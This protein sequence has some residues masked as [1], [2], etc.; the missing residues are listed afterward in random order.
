MKPSNKE[1]SQ[2]GRSS[3]VFTQTQKEAYFSN[4]SANCFFKK[5]SCLYCLLLICVLAYIPCFN[6]PLLPLLLVWR[7]HIIWPW[8]QTFAV[9]WMLYSFFWV[10]SRC[11][12]FI[13]RRFGTL[14]LFHLHRRAGM[15]YLII[16]V[17]W[18]RPVL[19]VSSLPYFLEATTDP[20]TLTKV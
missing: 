17:C 10:I 5:A 9:F 4:V 11:L 14:C 2:F 3:S 12:K 15:K 20:A 1:N 8:F 13:C 6:S 7:T 18:F 16:C 19:L